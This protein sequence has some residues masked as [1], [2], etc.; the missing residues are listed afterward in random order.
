MPPAA[1]G[2]FEAMLAREGEGRRD[3]IGFGAAHDE[4]GPP[5]DHGVPKLANL[6][7]A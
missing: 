2:E 6:V 5:F 7:I 3:V 4:G 1:N